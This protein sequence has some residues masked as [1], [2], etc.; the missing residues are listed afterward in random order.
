MAMQKYFKKN[1]SGEFEEIEV[2]D[3]VE[4]KTA[5]AKEREESKAAKQKAKE[6]EELRLKLEEDKMLKEKEFEKLWNSEKSAREMTAKELSDLKEQIANN[7]RS[8][9]ANKIVIG[10]TKDTSRAELLKKIAMEFIQNTPDG[11]KVLSPDGNIFDEKRLS[12][13]LSEKYPY[14]I[15]GYGSSGGGA[16]GSST[17]Y[18]GKKFSEMSEVEHVQLYKTD[19]EKWRKLKDAEKRKE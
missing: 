17:N 7:Q 5:L 13:H 14:L 11:I 1:E 16:K 12:D 2:D 18:S 10:L 4:L 19:P 15:D 8:E 3:A 9:L 6:L